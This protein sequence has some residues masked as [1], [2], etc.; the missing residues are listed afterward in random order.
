LL[1]GTAGRD[2]LPDAPESIFV[3][4]YVP[5]SSIMPRCAAIVHQGGIG[6]TAQALRAG[7]PMLV[8]PWSHDQPD[9]AERVRRLGVARVANRARYTAQRAE[10]E[11][12]IL[13]EEKRYDDRARRIAEE[14]AGEDGL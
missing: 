3:A 5:Y 1:A 10:R 14:I 7:R 11:L 9:N 13:L 8:V 2:V 6:T 4:D 12:R